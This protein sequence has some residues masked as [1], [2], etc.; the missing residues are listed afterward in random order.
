MKIKASIV[1]GADRTIE[2]MI[3]QVKIPFGV[4]QAL[5]P[6]VAECW[7]HLTKSL[8]EKNFRFELNSQL[9]TSE[10]IVFTYFKSLKYLLSGPSLK[11]LLLYFITPITNLKKSCSSNLRLLQGSTLVLETATSL[12]IAGIPFGEL[13]SPMRQTVWT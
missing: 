9:C 2:Q 4:N 8:G 13:S 7:R 3:L 11:I 5:P 1:L 6:R 10:H 12:N